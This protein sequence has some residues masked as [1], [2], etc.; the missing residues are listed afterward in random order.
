MSASPADT[1]TSAGQFRGAR[2]W[3]LARIEAR[4]SKH[5]VS[6]WR[7]YGRA[8][9]CTLLPRAI[10]TWSPLPWIVGQQAAHAA[11]VALEAPSV[12]RSSSSETADHAWRR[13]ACEA[14][15][16]STCCFT[17]PPTTSPRRHLRSS[18]RTRPGTRASMPVAIS[19]CSERSRIPSATARWRSSQP[20]KPPRSSPRGPFRGERRGPELAGARVERGPGPGLKPRGP[21]LGCSGLCRA[22]AARCGRGSSN[23][24]SCRE[25]RRCVRWGVRRPR[26]LA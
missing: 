3:P 8:K 25:E 21:V 9:I 18:L 11:M 26:A 24:L 5:Q 14:G 16:M 15:A 22:V 17:S 20:G 6:S 12:P 13:A 7:R 19:S 4:C 23:S 1:D 2:R 10:T